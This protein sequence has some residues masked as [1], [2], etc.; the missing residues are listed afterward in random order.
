M[1]ARETYTESR[2]AG[3]TKLGTN[4]LRFYMT[5]SWRLNG[6]ITCP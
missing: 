5:I 1:H 4:Y 3:L 6:G 2:V